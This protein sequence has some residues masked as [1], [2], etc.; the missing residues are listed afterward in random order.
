MRRLRGLACGLA[1]AA[2]LA[3]APAT[4]GAPPVSGFTIWT[5]A[6]NGSQ[7]AVATGTCGD[8][9]PA[10]D[11]PIITSGVAFDSKR[12]MYVSDYTAHK[13]RKVAPDGTISTIAGTGVACSGTGAA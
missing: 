1:A 4:V 6:G 9:G 10:T 11:A 2:L 3:A 13:V 5:V 12:N 8:G 7:C